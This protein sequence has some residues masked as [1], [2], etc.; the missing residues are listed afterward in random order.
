MHCN[1]DFSNIT[2]SRLQYTTW[3]YREEEENGILVLQDALHKKILELKELNNN[4]I[5]SWENGL[6]KI[7]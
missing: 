3:C 7:K 5:N 1:A 6:K 2:L 4:A